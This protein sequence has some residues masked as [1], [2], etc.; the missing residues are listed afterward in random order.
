VRYPDSQEGGLR[1]D[2]PLSA[3]KSWCP[4]PQPPVDPGYHS[5]GLRTVQNPIRYT[6][7]AGTFSECYEITE[8][9]N[10][11][12]V[13][14]WFCNGI[15]VVARKYDHSGTRFGYEDTLIRFSMSSPPR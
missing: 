6:T 15:G 7:P 1:Y 14:E 5:N 3:G 10:S 13:N 8:E 9:F 2:F 11:G 4:E 12:G